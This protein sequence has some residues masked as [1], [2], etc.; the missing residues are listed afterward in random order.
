MLLLF[1][2]QKQDKVKLQN[3]NKYMQAAIKYIAQ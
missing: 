3:W 1:S 2:S